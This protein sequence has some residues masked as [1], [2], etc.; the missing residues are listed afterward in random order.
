M[1]EKEFIR[2]YIVNG[3]IEW[4]RVFKDTLLVLY[5]DEVSNFVFTSE[6]GDFMRLSD[7]SILLCELVKNRIDPDE[8]I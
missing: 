7:H 6:S 1:K 8:A 4:D 5:G 3:K 2:F